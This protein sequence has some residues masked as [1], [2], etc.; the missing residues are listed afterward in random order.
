VNTTLAQGIDQN[1]AAP[2]TDLF[3]YNPAQVALSL[4]V[5]PLTPDQIAAALPS[6]T[7]GNGNALNL[8]ALA[9]AKTLNGYAFAQFYGN[10]VD[11]WETI[12]PSQKQ[13]V[14]RATFAESDA[15]FTKPGFGSVAE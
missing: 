15:G 12:Y 6:A 7:G 9:D 1:G 5:N 13:S 4:A 10:L 3:T 8:A 14:D 2:T 11:V